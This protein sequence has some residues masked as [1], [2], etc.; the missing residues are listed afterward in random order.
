MKKKM[1][2]D[3]KVDYSKFENIIVSN[4]YDIKKEFNDKP[5]K[6]HYKLLSH[7]STLYN[8]CNIID[9]GS[10]RGSSAC[11]L[12][13]NPTNTVMS[14]D[15][16]NNVTNEAIR[17]IPNIKFIIANIFE[18]LSL[19]KDLLM[20]AP[21]IFLDIDPHE[22]NMEYDFYLQ[23]K[24]WNYQGILVCD[25]IWH[26]ESMRNNFWYKI[27]DQYKY[28]VTDW[29]H[30]SGTGIVTFNHEIQFPKHI[31]DNWTLVTAYF[32]LTKCPDASTEI[33]A[34]DQSYYMVNAYST[35]SLPN[36]LVIYCDRDSYDMIY[37]IRPDYLRDKTKYVICEF[38]DFTIDGIKYSDL[39]NIINHNRVTH[40]YHF[41]N[42]NTAS[43]Y[44][45]CMSRYIMLKSVIEEN[46][47]T[48]THFAWINICM[49]RMGI[50]NIQ[51]LPEALS[52]G[53]DK[54]STVYID[55]I[56]KELVDKPEEYWT[57]GKCSF[58]SGFFTGNSYY[59]NLFCTLILEKFT[60]YLKMGRG[61]ADEQLYSPV[62]F[63]NPDIFE[64]YYGDYQEMI[65]NYVY[66]YDNP[67]KIV[68]IFIANSY[69]H[70]NYKKCAEACEFLYNSIRHNKCTISPFQL[71]MLNNIYLSCKKLL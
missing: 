20:N 62:Y 27:E 24:E 46:P 71:M 35:L 13:Y 32:N 65:T 66:V 14:F 15:I 59:M 22:G 1:N 23:L 30:W 70:K 63:E 3:I 53:R 38:D 12:S 8:N 10:H 40:P 50:K 54:F 34:R 58:C 4:D 52:L 36:N 68:N 25:D 21:I 45:F 7:L 6:E 5:G 69:Q 28:D 55:Y 49:Q 64:N 16:I 2:L 9:I 57:N 26:F 47:F 60:Y 33:K 31:N 43:Y 18:H 51:K 67:D 44:L 17:E 11:A 39:R 48:S 56:P 61:H 41:D 42:R 19:F 37:A 29:G